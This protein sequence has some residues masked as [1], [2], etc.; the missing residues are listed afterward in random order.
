MRLEDLAGQV[1][2]TVEGSPEYWLDHYYPAVTP[3]GKPVFRLS[4]TGSWQELLA[5]VGRDA[6]VAVAALQGVRFYPRPG[7]VYV[8]FEDAGPIV[9]GLTWRAAGATARVPA[10]V[11]AATENPPRAADL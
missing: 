11:R 3:S 8:P 5:S 7:I 2:L 9:Y 10:F 4:S 1:L 6:G